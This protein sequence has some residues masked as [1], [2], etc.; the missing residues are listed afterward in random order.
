MSI[1]KDRVR[2]VGLLK[3]VDG[4]SAEEFRRR[5]TDLVGS[6]KSLPISQKKLLKYEMVSAH[7]VRYA[8]RD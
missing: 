7:H 3:P 8:S 2:Y 1:R 5:M 6:I 4:L